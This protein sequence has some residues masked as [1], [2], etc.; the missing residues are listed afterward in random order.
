MDSLLEDSAEATWV[1]H[2]HALYLC[3]LLE[4][5]YAGSSVHPGAWRARAAYLTNIRSALDWQLRQRDETELLARLAAA[6]T[7]FLLDLSLLSECVRWASI[8]LNALGDRRGSVQE[9]E[10][11][12]SLGLALLFSGGRLEEVQVALTR[13]LELADEQRDPYNQVRVLGALTSFYQRNGDAQSALQLAERARSVARP[14]DDPTLSAMADWLLGS[15]SHLAGEHA[16]ARCIGEGAWFSPQLTGRVKRA[17]FGFDDHRIRALCG[18]ARSLW[19]LGKADE[20]R[21]AVP[22]ILREAERFGQPT[23]L[24]VVLSWLTPVWVWSG[25]WETADEYLSR[26]RT[27]AEQFPIGIYRFVAQALQ[28][29][30]AIERGQAA[31]GLETL[32]EAFEALRRTR[33]RTFEV[34]YSPP[35]ALALA[36]LGRPDD[37]LNAIDTALEVDAGFGGSFVSPELLRVKGNLLAQLPARE[38]EAAEELLR[39]S[40]E[41]A[42]RQGALGWQLR[43]ATS[44]ARLARPSLPSNSARTLLRQTYAQFSQGFETRDLILA[45]QLLEELTREP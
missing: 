20:A 26:L 29:E 18:W 4:R 5:Y 45:R 2:R 15:S 7:P 8:G 41:G 42:R 21:L 22:R 30:L 44:L 43:S 24:A 33:F 12:A 19:M 16:S 40:F 3:E 11:Q 37:A 10:L 34:I 36:Q 23:A 14:A 32:L 6:A 1:G 9:L 31:V 39:Q 38:A 27:H 35:L 17:R 25:D 13:A 28:G